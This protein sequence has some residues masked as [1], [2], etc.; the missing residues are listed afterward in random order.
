MTRLT[1]KS[2]LAIGQVCL[3][4]ST[5]L[6]AV[7]LHMV[8]DDRVTATK[9]RVALCEA[10]AVNGSAF[11]SRDDVRRLEALLV[12]VVERNE[13][14]LS[15]AVRRGDGTL[16]CEVGDHAAH[17]RPLDKGRST[18]AQMVVPLQHGSGRWGAIEFRFRPLYASGLA[19]FLW[20]PWT[21][22]VLFMAGASLVQFRWYLG[23]MLNHLDPSRAVPD[24]VRSALDTLAEGLLVL[25]T[26][27][28]IMLAN[29]A[30][31]SALGQTPEE[32]L[33]RRASSLPWRAP[34]ESHGVAALPWT[35]TLATQ[36]AQSGVLIGLA[37][38]H[39][40]VRSLSVH[41]SPVLSHEGQ[42]RGV[43]VTFDDVTEVLQLRVSRSV[44]ASPCAIVAS[45]HWMLLC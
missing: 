39:G 3:V 38:N 36:Q 11:V 21:M 14:L 45:E 19:G 13:D 8:P 15:A 34:H 4:I 9:G 40:Q 1:A 30:F 10:V 16:V 12:S 42:Y 32:L 41:S 22:L 5:L 6:M 28:R 44:V 7:L 29:Q 31:A 35:T 24:R 37:G 33:G 23:K 17:W 18:E 43:L 26:Q 27:E 2:R 25:D 20:H